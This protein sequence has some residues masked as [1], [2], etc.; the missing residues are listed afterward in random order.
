MDE[1]TQSNEGTPS[2]T[3]ADF[4]EVEKA[5][6]PTLTLRDGTEIPVPHIQAKRVISLFRLSA[7]IMDEKRPAAQRLVDY[8]DLLEQFADAVGDDRLLE[9]DIDEFMEVYGAFFAILVR[10]LGKAKAPARASR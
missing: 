4:E 7:S 3:T 5:L 2:V 10:S 9:L 8:A 1:T 6:D